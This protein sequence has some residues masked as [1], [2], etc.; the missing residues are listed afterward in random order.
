[1]TDELQTG[2]KLS[3][4]IVDDNPGSLEYLSAALAAPGLE[5]FTAS[6]GEEGL[7]LIY[8]HRPQ[9]VLSDLIMPTL[10]G[11]DV[12]RMVKEFDPRIS[13][14]IMSSADPDR[15]MAK[16]LE[17]TGADYLKKP[18][19][20]SVLRNCIGQL[21]QNHG[22]RSEHLSGQNGARSRPSK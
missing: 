15:A 13:V 12:L 20:L 3:I 16:I 5:T 6:S 14:V 18:I 9:I 11:L 10:S 17:Q 22:G 2:C 21:I 1:M 4:V 19:A 7:T 8:T